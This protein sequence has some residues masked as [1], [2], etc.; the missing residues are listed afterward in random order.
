MLADMVVVA[1]LLF[2]PLLTGNLAFLRV[3]REVHL[4]TSDN[5]P[6]LC[7]CRAYRPDTAATAAVLR[8]KG[9][10]LV[11]VGVRRAHLD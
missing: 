10:F 2:A 7:G 6:I 1:N 9:G 3:L 4:D 5:P 8:L 11:W